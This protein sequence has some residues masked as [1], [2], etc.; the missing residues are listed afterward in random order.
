M[1]RQAQACL[2][3]TGA[4]RLVGEDYSLLDFADQEADGFRI[5]AM[6][7]KTHF[8]RSYLFRAVKEYVRYR[9]AGDAVVSS[10]G[11]AAGLLVWDV[12][13]NFNQ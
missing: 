6:A 8:N 1:I 10:R 9:Y 11:I 7:R 5:E 3:L 13:A 2:I 4:E 12:S